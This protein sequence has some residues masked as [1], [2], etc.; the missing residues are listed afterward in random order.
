M[1]DPKKENQ[2]RSDFQSEVSNS[3]IPQL[4]WDDADG[5]NRL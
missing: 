1:W 4:A 5:W 2:L 3:F